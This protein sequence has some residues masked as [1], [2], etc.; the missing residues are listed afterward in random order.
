MTIFFLKTQYNS[1]YSQIF[2]ETYIKIKNHFYMSISLVEHHRSSRRFYLVDLLAFYSQFYKIV[3]KLVRV[4]TKYPISSKKFA[5]LQNKQKMQFVSRYQTLKQIQKFQFP[6]PSIQGFRFDK[7]FCQ[8]FPKHDKSLGYNKHQCYLISFN[9]KIIQNSIKFRQSVRIS[10][11]L[12][13]LTLFLRKSMHTHRSV[14][15]W[16]ASLRIIPKPGVLVGC[17]PCNVDN[18]N[19][20]MEARRP[21]LEKKPYTHTHTY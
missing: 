18:K 21:W 3:Q 8:I 4:Q 20:R 10:L 17:V 14:G 12:Y 11:K 16:C 5:R 9:M 2:R 1:Y 6:Q 19:Q 13:V 7:D 15:N